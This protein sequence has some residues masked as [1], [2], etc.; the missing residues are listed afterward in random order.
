MLSATVSQGNEVYFWKTMPRSLLGPFTG[1]PFTRI[2]PLSGRSWPATIRRS[3]DLP[4]PEGP[5]STRNSPI[6][7][8]AGEKASSTSRLMSFSASMRSPLGDMKVRLTLLMEILYFLVSMGHRLAMLAGAH[9]CRRLRGSLCGLAPREQNLFQEGEQRA[10]QECGHADGNDTG[11][12]QVRPM[13]LFCRLDHCAHSTI[14]VHNLR[15]NHVGPADVI[16]DAEGREY[17][18]K[19]GAEHQPQNLATLG[20][21]RVCGLQQRVINP[22]DL[23]HHHRQQVKEHAEPEEDD[24]HPLFDSEQAD[25]RGQKCGDRHGA[26]GRGNRINEVINPAKTGHQQ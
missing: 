19:R 4:Q 16:E 6:S 3:V 7:R 1:S 12:D 2:S 22:V 17:S 14:A 26:H 25:E 10:E 23:L 24:L 13:K 9:G 18:W 11:V 21:E 5:S 8:P 15:Q 20:A